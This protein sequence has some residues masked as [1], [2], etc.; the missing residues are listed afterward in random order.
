M[1]FRADV[2][3]IRRSA[4]NL[5]TDGRTVDEGV[6]WNLAWLTAPRKKNASA[7]YRRT[8]MCFPTESILCARAIQTL[9]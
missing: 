4:L 1:Y 3:A 8:C 6:A 9:F 2:D 5:R 7:F